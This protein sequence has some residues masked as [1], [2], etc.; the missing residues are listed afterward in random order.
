MF[1]P[2]EYS[3]R[4]QQEVTETDM[5]TYRKTGHVASTLEVPKNNCSENTVF[6][7]TTRFLDNGDIVEVD[8]NSKSQSFT[9]CLIREQQPGFIMGE[10]AGRSFLL[11]HAQHK[12]LLKSGPL[13]DSQVCN[14]KKRTAA[15]SC[16]SLVCVC[17]RHLALIPLR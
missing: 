8:A 9:L 16:A 4:Q 14:G 2:P 12:S 10:R 1:A 17:T 7:S 15:A 13:T 5:Q 3:Q 6:G 11:T